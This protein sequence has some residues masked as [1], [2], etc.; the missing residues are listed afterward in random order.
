LLL[1]RGGKH[2]Y[3]NVAPVS[4]MADLLRH[5]GELSSKPAR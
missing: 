5:V 1:A 3:E 2:V 4:T